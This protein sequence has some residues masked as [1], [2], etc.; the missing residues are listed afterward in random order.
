MDS[1]FASVWVEFESH[2][3]LIDLDLTL[4]RFVCHLKRKCAE[5]FC[6]HLRGIDASFIQLKKQGV[7][8]SPSMLTAKAIESVTAE[9]PLL[10]EKEVT[11]CSHEVPLLMSCACMMG[12]PSAS[13]RSFLCIP[14]LSLQPKRLV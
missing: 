13:T 5:A 10:I 14:F 11:T 1:S 9:E 4:C 6:N 2:K 3:E 7:V 8:L 12:L